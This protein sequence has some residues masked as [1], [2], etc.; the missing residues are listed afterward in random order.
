MTGVQCNNSPSTLKGDDTEIA[1]ETGD[2]KALAAWE[3]VSVT[4]SFLIASWLVLPFS[5]NSKLIV[6]VPIA[7]AFALMW[8]SYCL[9]GETMHAVGLRRDNFWPAV[10]LLLLPMLCAA[11]V[12]V[13]IGWWNR[14]LRFESLLRARFILLPVWALAQQYVLQGFINRRAQV[15][16]GTGKRSV[17]LVGALFALLHLPNFWLTVATFT[18]GILWAYA[19]QKAPNLFALALSH[20]VMSLLVA[21]SLPPSAINSLRVGFKYFG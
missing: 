5:G 3:I 21:L 16:W 17:V 4:S 6:S 7:L 11:I 10:R 19:Y 12:I 13:F 18:G 1:L 20:S 2:S 9:R 15:I 8:V 14:S